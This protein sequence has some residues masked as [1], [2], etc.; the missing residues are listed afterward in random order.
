MRRLVAAAVVLA[1][2]GA[3]GCDRP[4]GRLSVEVL[5]PVTAA[6][7]VF[8]GNCFTGWLVAVQLRLRETEGVDVA[9]ERVSYRL[10]DEGAGR[11]LLAET[12]DAAQVEE[13]A[14]SRLVP[15]RGELRFPITAISTGEP[16]G[17]VVFE[18]E[19]LG[20]DESGHAIVVPLRST[21]TMTVAPPPAL[22]AGACGPG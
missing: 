21:A 13:R 10:A 12:L 20:R 1:A 18:G 16:I 15:A 2:A 14:G 9:L 8:H 3:G 22:G 4:A 7:L 5:G 6:P 11:E 17:P 19:I